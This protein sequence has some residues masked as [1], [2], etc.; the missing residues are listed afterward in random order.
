MPKIPMIPPQ[1][2]DGRT[3]S[4]RFNSFAKKL[5]GVPKAAIDRQEKREAGKGKKRKAG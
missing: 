3:E 2:D 5:L 1:P 4:Q